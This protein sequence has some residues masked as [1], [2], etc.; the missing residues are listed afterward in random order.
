MILR[1]SWPL[2]GVVVSLGCAQQVSSS[3]GGPADAALDG[4]ATWTWTLAAGGQHSCALRSDGM[5]RCWGGNRMGALGD[6]TQTRRVSPVTVAD[7]TDA[8]GIT[9]GNEHTCAWLRD[10]TARCWGRNDFGGIGDGT[11]AHRGTPTAVLGLGGVASLDTT[12]LFTCAALRDGTAR[13]WGLGGAHLGD[14]TFTTPYQTTPVAVV[15]LTG[16]AGVVAGG[17]HSCAWLRDG[18]VRCWGNNRYGRLGDG[19]VG[20]ERSVPGPVV[21][22]VE[23]AGLAAGDG[24]VCAWLRDGSVRC[25]GANHRGQLGDG[26]LTDRARPVNVAGLS[27]VTRVTAG[28]A[29]ACARRNDGTAWCWGN[30]YDG[31]LGDGTTVGRATTARVVGLVD[32]VGIA[33]GGAHT[34]AWRRDGMVWCWG[35][36]EYGQLGDGTTVHRLAPVLVTGL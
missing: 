29:Y 34:C 4:S 16:V 26:T 1:R 33:A 13:C 32:V 21:D 23:V 19:T 24:F 10:G 18:T 2:V 36:N 3:H 28:P 14:G 31:Q 15:G 27:G 25:W 12:S 20:G 30:N 8:A 22:L 35:D 11:T 5:V 6:G 7:L 9:A 17:G